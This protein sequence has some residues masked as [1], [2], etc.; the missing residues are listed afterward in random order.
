MDVVVVVVVV[1]VVAAAA[2]D[3]VVPDVHDDDD[4]DKSNNAGD[5]FLIHKS[6]VELSCDNIGNVY[7]FKIDVVVSVVVVV[8]FHVL[9]VDG[10]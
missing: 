9:L 1:V 3:V 10:T 6:R 2:A 8:P 7:L 4:D 5:I